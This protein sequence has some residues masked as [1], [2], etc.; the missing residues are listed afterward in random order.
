MKYDVHRSSM[1]SLNTVVF[2]SLLFTATFT[3]QN[4][5]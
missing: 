1:Q 3:V 5:E 2:T 4:E